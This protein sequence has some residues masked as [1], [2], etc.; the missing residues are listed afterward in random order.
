MRATPRAVADH[1][2]G[3][4]VLYALRLRRERRTGEPLMTTEL[5]LPTTLAGVVTE[6][7]LAERPFYRLLADA[8]V[9]VDRMD[10]E[11]T[12]EIAGPRNAQL[13]NTAI[14]APLI[15][16]NRLA[17]VAGAPHHVMSIVLSPD[18]SRVVLNHSFDE[19]NDG[20]RLAIAHDVRRA[21]G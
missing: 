14:G 5:W 16:V 11:L 21:T 12:A 8:G 19:P 20:S 17:V 18:R 10:H 2:G 6:R 3:E 15:R 4:Q 13:M 9:T 1:L 7:A